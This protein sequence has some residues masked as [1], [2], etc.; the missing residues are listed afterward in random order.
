MDNKRISAGGL[1]GVVYIQLLRGKDLR[2]KNAP[3]AVMQV[4]NF[5][6]KTEEKKQSPVNAS[7]NFFWCFKS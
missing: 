5:S 6:V 7:F 4:G 1:K 2:A 3:Y